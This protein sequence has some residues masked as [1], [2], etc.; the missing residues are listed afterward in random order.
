MGEVERIEL[1]GKFGVG[2][3]KKMEPKSLGFLLQQLGGWCHHLWRCVKVGR[4]LV[5]TTGK[6]HYALYH[7]YIKCDGWIR[8]ASISITFFYSPMNFVHSSV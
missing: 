5:G 2:R 6:E 1:C 3:G 4:E 7:G 8:H